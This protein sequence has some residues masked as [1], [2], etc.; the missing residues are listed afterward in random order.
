MSMTEKQRFYQAHLS[1]AGEANQPLAVYARAQGINV[2][3]L[4]SE[5]RRLRGLEQKSLPAFVRVEEA[6]LPSPTLLQIRLP[7]GVSLALP[8]HQVSI[9]QMLL[10]LAKL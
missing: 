5:K 10:T 8:T 4:Y 3:S 7:N 1:A 2:H 9:D 6:S